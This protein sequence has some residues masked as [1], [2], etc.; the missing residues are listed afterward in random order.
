ML[1]PELV[2]HGYSLGYFPM[3]MEDGQIDWF[4]PHDRAL[5]PL[6]GMHVSRSLRRT[7]RRGGFAVTF[8][9]AFTEVMRGCLR[10]DANW[11]SDVFIEVYSQI[12][13]DG[14]AHSCEVWR[15]DELVGGAYG[16][17][18]GSCFCAESMF[19]RR[20]D[21]SKIALH[22]LIERC[23]DLG[24]TLFDAQVMTPHLA[25]LGAYN[26]PHEEYMQL[27]RAALGQITPWTR[28]VFPSVVSP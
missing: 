8:D 6:S 27:L 19:H 26:V 5:F 25:S 16:V 22:A 17:V 3:T 11:I 24:F 28:I 23:R 21:M 9:R 1:T 14:W 18:I 7:M 15:D 4:R 10:P 2:W 20:S 13:W 12:H